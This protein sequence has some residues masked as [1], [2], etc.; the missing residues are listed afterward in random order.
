MNLKTKARPEKAKSNL[1]SSLSF[2]SFFFFL[3][4]E[5]LIM[6]A[7]DSQ[8]NHKSF[9]FF[10]FFFVRIKFTNLKISLK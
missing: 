4:T 9:F 1:Q 8:K 6:I 3:S 5:D 7:N 10:F 2:L